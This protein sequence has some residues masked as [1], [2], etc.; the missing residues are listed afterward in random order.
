MFI[1]ASDYSDHYN[2]KRVG[3]TSDLPRAARYWHS[4]T[5]A[6]TGVDYDLYWPEQ[7]TDFDA[8]AVGG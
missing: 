5:D 4:V 8:Y 2:V 6:L 7:G 1:I 3:S